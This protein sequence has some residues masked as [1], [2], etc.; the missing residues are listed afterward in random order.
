MALP[1][2]SQRLFDAK[3][4]RWCLLRKCISDQGLLYTGE[5]SVT[6]VVDP[7]KGEAGRIVYD[8]TFEPPD[9]GLDECQIPNGTHVYDNGT[10]RQWV[11]IALDPLGINLNPA[12][13]AA[14]FGRSFKVRLDRT[15]LSPEENRAWNALVAF[16]SE[17]MIR[18]IEER[19]YTPIEVHGDLLV[20]RTTHFTSPFETV[21]IPRSRLSD[22]M[23][24]G[25]PCLSA[26]LADC[27]NA[28]QRGAIGKKYL[29]PST[30]AYTIPKE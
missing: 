26:K 22:T 4:F 1:L 28:I 8:V 9:G 13:E 10:W 12:M 6:S 15:F 23:R 25:I 2:F 27:E 30:P 29:S 17:P 24:C 3:V 20:F 5:I 11:G 7:S 16:A 21:R 18:E 14:S 19:A